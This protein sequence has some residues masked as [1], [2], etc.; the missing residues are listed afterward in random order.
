MKELNDKELDLIIAQTLQR[1]HIVEKISKTTLIHV[2]KINRQRRVRHAFRII[3]FAFGVPLMLAVM[4]FGA[5]SIT[6]ITEGVMGY[7]AA[8][9]TVISAVGVATYSITNFSLAKM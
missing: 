3:G 2:K 8:A 7:I 6:T 5:Y 1:K 9:I 4:G